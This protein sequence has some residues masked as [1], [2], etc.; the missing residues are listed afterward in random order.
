[1]SHSKIYRRHEKPEFATPGSDTSEYDLK[2][3]ISKKSTPSLSSLETELEDARLKRISNVSKNP[4]KRRRVAEVV[5]DETV[6]EPVPSDVKRRVRNVEEDSDDGMGEMPLEMEVDDEGMG[7]ISS[8]SYETE[9]SDGDEFFDDEPVLDLKFVQKERRNT[10]VTEEDVEREKEEK[11]ERE[12]EEWEERRKRTMMMMKEKVA[13]EEDDDASAD[14]SSSEE[15]DEET[16]QKEFELWKLRE[17][18]RIK[19]EFEDIEKHK[20]E[21]EEK[22]KRQNM[23]DADI[24]KENEKIG[25]G[26][27][28]RKTEMRFLQKYYHEGAFYKDELKDVHSKHDYLLPTGEDKQDKTIL[29]SIMQVRRYGLASR[30]KYTHL[31]NEDTSIHDDY[32][33]NEHTL[34]DKY[35][36]KIAGTRK[37]ERPRKKRKIE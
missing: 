3:I 36:E 9:S 26:E 27:K 5:Q 17:L 10:I 25:R 7:A 32:W 34:R 12:L 22:E 13:E 16:R 28:L 29:P 24:V 20:E 23:S 2:K 4:Q 21:M 31:T 33:R 8:S 14:I 30:T 37:M 1:M 15:D 18:R 19:R 35:V 11:E 6:V